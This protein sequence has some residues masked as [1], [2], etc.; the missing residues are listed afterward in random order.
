MANTA[1]PY[2]IDMNHIYFLKPIA[3]TIRAAAKAAQF[4]GGGRLGGGQGRASESAGGGEVWGRAAGGP[5]L[6]DFDKIVLERKFLQCPLSRKR[7]QSVVWYD[8]VNETR[9]AFWSLQTH[10]GRR[11]KKIAA[12]RNRVCCRPGQFRPSI[13]PSK[14]GAK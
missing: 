14:R 12:R 5:A 10:N 9:A 7:M 6:S 11:R 8:F 1:N 4:R 3:L 2:P 13:N